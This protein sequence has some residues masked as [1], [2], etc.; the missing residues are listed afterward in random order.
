MG[1]T[2]HCREVGFECGG[3]FR[4]SREDEILQLAAK[5]AKTVFGGTP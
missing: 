5:H 2:I 3:V 1:K 4:T